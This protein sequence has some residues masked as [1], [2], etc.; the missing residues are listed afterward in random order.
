MNYVKIYNNLI[1]SSRN[2]KRTKK[3]GTYYEEHHILPV[4]WGG[5]DESFNL[6]LLTAKEHW[7]AH[8]L[9]SKIATGKNSYKA[10][11]AVVCMGRV[12]SENKRKTSSLYAAARQSIAKEIS[13]RYSNTIVVKELESGIRI[14]RVSKTHPKVLSGEW[15]FFHTGMSRTDEWKLK[16]GKSVSGEKNGTFTGMSN[17]AIIDRCKEVFQ[18]YGYWNYNITR[19]YCSLKYGE[20]IPTS[21]CGKYRQPIIT[22]AIQKILIDMFSA[23]EKQFGS[24]AKHHTNEIKKEIENEFK[25]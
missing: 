6:V 8:L 15:V 13:I 18:R 17:D 7:I 5:S 2:K 9:L 22:D 1:E 12:I 14:G 24:Y 10:N 19:L 23:T 25:N 20:K 11:Q 16:V 3:D 4:S 21:F